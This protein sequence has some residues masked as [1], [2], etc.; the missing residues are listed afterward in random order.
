[1]RIKYLLDTNAVIALIN[2][3][4]QLADATETAGFVDLSAVAFT[5]IPSLSILSY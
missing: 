4:K 1:M 3:N 5:K 2:G